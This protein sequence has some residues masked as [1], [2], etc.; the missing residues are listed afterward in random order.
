[1]LLWLLAEIDRNLD[2]V[3]MLREDTWGADILLYFF[4]QR[5]A[6]LKTLTVPLS[7][8]FRWLSSA[9]LQCNNNIINAKN[10]G[11]TT[12]FSLLSELSKQTL[13]MD[14]PVLNKGKPRRSNMSCNIGFFTRLSTSQSLLSAGLKLTFK[15]SKWMSKKE[16]YLSIQG[17]AKNVFKVIFS[18]VGAVKSP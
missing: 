17:V 4:L 5:P 14:S 2:L 7:G 13:K 6:A 12:H 18:S 3:L 15:K 8:S 10:I 1:M 16:T 11:V 9:S